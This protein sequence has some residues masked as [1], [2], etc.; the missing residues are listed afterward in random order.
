MPD[1]IEV[2]IPAPAAA[3]EVLVT[4][5]PIAIE[6]AVPGIQGPAG[7]GALGDI[8]LGTFN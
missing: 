6:V 5:Q 4:P 3:V 2:V 1:V 8:D 7:D